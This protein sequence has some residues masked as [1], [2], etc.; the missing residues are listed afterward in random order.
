LRVADSWTSEVQVHKLVC[1]L[2]AVTV[3]SKSDSLTADVVMSPLRNVSIYTAR[4]LAY[5]KMECIAIPLPML[6]Q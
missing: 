1:P 3:D 6:L 4:M 5:L 2:V